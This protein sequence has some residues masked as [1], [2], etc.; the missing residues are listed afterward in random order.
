MTT[1]VEVAE[2][3]IT[4]TLTVTS[5]SAVAS[6]TEI[7]VAVTDEQ[8]DVT[9]TNTQSNV[10]CESSESVVVSANPTITVVTAAAQGPPG[11]SATSDATEIIDAGETISALKPIA[12]VNGAGVVASNAN[13]NHSGFLA[14]ISISSAT[15]GNSFTNQTFGTLQDDS[16]NWNPAIP[17]IFV[18]NGVLTQTPP[19]SGWLQSIAR[20]E[21]SDTIF[22]QLGELI[23]RV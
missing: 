19:T 7:S 14:G 4:V 18:G 2:D 20:V 10:T 16:W 8:V 13:A 12:V 15:T 3:P 9:A 1:T 22:I 11:A 23:E 17:W 5:V 21:S 6:A